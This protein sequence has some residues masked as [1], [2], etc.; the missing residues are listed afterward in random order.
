MIENRIYIDNK[1]VNIC[2]NEFVLMCNYTN[3]KKRYGNR[4]SVKKLD[5]TVNDK[6]KQEWLNSL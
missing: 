1:L 5:K 6:E 3:Y 4:V 2:Y